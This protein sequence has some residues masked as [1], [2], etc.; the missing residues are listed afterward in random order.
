MAPVL[1]KLFLIYARAVDQALSVLLAQH[2]KQRMGAANLLFE[3][4]H[5]GRQAL[6]QSN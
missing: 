5:E 6:V 2:G 4:H 1:G 3:L